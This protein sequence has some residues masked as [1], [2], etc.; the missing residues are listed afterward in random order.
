MGMQ[1]QSRIKPV[2]VGVGVGEVDLIARELRD[3]GEGEGVVGYGAA[4]AAD[5]VGVVTYVRAAA[6][7]ATALQLH[8]HLG[9]HKRH[10]AAVVPGRDKRVST[11][12]VGV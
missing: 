5:V 6:L 8:R 9:V 1:P 2:G 10:E 12:N 4:L 3:E 7:P 11:Q